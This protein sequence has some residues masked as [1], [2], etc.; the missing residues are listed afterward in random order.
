[1]ACSLCCARSEGATQ[2]SFW[3][4]TNSTIPA[5]CDESP[6]KLICYKYIWSCICLL[7]LCRP[8]LYYHAGP[9]PNRICQKN[10][11]SF[12]RMQILII[13]YHLSWCNHLSCDNL[14]S[15]N[16]FIKLRAAKHTQLKIPLQEEYDWS[17]SSTIYMCSVYFCIEV[18]Y[19]PPLKRLNQKW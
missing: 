18:I 11:V 7:R 8:K 19:T 12:G 13:K 6:T 2:E 17:R 5:L 1:M 16:E 9:W 10:N 14:M 15:N 4:R 3:W